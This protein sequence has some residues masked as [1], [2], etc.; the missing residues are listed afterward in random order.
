MAATSNAPS[1]SGSIKS[2]FATNPVVRIHRSVTNYRDAWRKSPRMT[3]LRTALVGAGIAFT[4]INPLLTIGGA[5]FVYAMGQ[6]DERNSERITKIKEHARAGTL[7]QHYPRMDFSSPRAIKESFSKGFRLG[8]KN[9]VGKPPS[10]RMLKF[11]GGAGVS[12]ICLG[13]VAP[14]MLAGMMALDKAHERYQVREA[15]KDLKKHGRP[16]MVNR[17]PKL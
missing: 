17:A 4:I 2:F 6:Q 9:S 14:I 12:F 10:R 15:Y 11:A 3:A 1:I 16:A 8:M 7:D 5:G 13:P